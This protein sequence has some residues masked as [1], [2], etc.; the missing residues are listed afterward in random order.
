MFRNIQEFGSTSFEEEIQDLVNIP[1][2]VGL[3]GKTYSALVLLGI[4][5]PCHPP[6]AET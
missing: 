6:P 1:R 2:R 3:R 4:S 5:H